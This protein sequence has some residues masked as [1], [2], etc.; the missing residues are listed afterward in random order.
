MYLNFAVKC[1]GNSLRLAFFHS[2]Q[3]SAQDYALTLE[4]ENHIQ[5]NVLLAQRM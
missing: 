1:R 3:V 5:S 4:D 2:N